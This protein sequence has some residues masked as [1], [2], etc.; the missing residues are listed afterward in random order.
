MQNTKNKLFFPFKKFYVKNIYQLKLITWATSTTIS[1]KSAAREN[2]T[3]RIQIDI[4]VSEKMSNKYFID[5]VIDFD[6]QPRALCVCSKA[7][8]HAEYKWKEVK[9]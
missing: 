3:N 1:V 7:K 4:T 2:Q 9:K 8:K 5:H 6:A